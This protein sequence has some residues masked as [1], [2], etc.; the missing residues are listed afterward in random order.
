MDSEN[1]DIIAAAGLSAPVDHCSDGDV[2]DGKIYCPI[3]EYPDSAAAPNQ[4]LCIFDA[5]DLSFVEKFD[6]GSQN[7]AQYSGLTYCDKDDLIYLC[8][9]N[10]G[11]SES[12]AAVNKLYKFDPTDGSYLG[13]LDLDKPIHSA[14]GVKWWRNHFWLNNDD[15]DETIRVSYTGACSV[16]N[17][18]EG[19][20]GLTGQATAGNYEGIGATEEELLILID[21]G[22]T[23]RVEI[24][25][26]LDM[27]LGAGGGIRMS[28]TSQSVTATG[29]SSMTSFLI[30]GSVELNAKTGSSQGI[31]TY[32]DTG[33]GSPGNRVTLAF[34]DNAGTTNDGLGVWDSVNAW[35]QDSPQDNPSTG[36]PKRLWA[37]YDDTD[38]ALYIDGVLANS[39]AGITAMGSNLDTVRIGNTTTSSGEGPSADVG[40]CYLRPIPTNVAAWLAAEYANL[41]DPD[42]F[43]TVVEN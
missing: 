34:R 41:N 2:H 12:G 24:R 15:A 39:Q 9:W 6:I 29:R 25:R 11:S 23:E 30:G 18:T 21:P 37:V 10:T 42:S 22:T 16:G 40:F 17:L 31:C 43:Y 19:T 1:T 33:S 8:A 38:R 36:V 27:P 4:W 7:Y 5:G 32:Y 3:Q 13:T 26:P 20:G 14:Q 35:L 28:S